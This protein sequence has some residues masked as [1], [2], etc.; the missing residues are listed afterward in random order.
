ME[1]IPQDVALR[2]QLAAIAGDER[3][4]SYLYLLTKRGDVVVNQDFIPVRELERAAATAIDRSPLGNVYVGCAPRITRSGRKRAICR[5]WI[6]PADCDSTLS[7]ARLP[8]FQPSPPLVN[9]SGT[10]DRT[11]SIWP[12]SEPLTPAAA[13]IA[14]KRL[15]RALGADSACTHAASMLRPI[16]SLNHKHSPPIPVRCV[17]LKLD[18]FTAAQVVGDLDD[19]EQRERPAITIARTNGTCL[20]D[21]QL[22][23]QSIPSGEFVALLTGREVTPAGFV[24][25]PFHKGGRERTPSLHVSAIDAHWYCHACRHGGGLP[26]FYALLYGQPVPDRRDKHAFV[27]LAYEIKAAL[28]RRQL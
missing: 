25:C 10:A 27:K 4:E 20:A 13:E 2:L 24:Q 9:R 12:L 21:G 18:V 7:S 5:V 26:E 15:A 16:G 19:V 22:D 28:A 3:A 8:K 6:L 14:N 17:R 11:Q 23:V 1:P